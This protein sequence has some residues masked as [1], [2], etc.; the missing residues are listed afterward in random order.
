MPRTLVETTPTFR[1]YV[2]TDG[3]GKVIGE[4]KEQILNPEQT[5]AQVI[6]QRAATAVANNQTFLAIASPT[7]AQVSAQVTALTKQ[8]DGLIRFA[9]NIFDG[10]D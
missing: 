6:A 5:N 1:R 2:V 4:D 8:V 3:A 9:F 7:A 10:T